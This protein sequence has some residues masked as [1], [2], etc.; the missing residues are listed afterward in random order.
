MIFAISVTLFIFY[1]SLNLLILYLGRMIIYKK[2]EGER[3]RGRER[4]RE[5][6]RE[7]VYNLITMNT[8]YMGSGL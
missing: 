7:N 2:K 3:E 4:G 6:E 5:R 8:G 1:V